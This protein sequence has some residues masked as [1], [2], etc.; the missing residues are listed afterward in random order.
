MKQLKTTLPHIG[1]H[2]YQVLHRHGLLLEA[3]RL[4]AM[5]DQV[6]LYS[7]ELMF[8]INDYKNQCTV[9]K[10]NQYFAVVHAKPNF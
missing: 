5:D 7:L 3:V 10:L 8:M 9:H 1:S 4:P 6:L 2:L